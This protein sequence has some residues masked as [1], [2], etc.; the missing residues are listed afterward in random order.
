MTDSNPAKDIVSEFA[1][2]DDSGSGA[3]PLSDQT[4]SAFNDLWNVEDRVNLGTSEG[5]DMSE[6]LKFELETLTIER[7]R[8]KKEKWKLT[9]MLESIKL[10]EEIALMKSEVSALDDENRQLL[11]EIQRRKSTVSQN[12]PG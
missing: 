5:N 8:L 12:T 11:A 1:H 10:E 4:D 3:V 2:I 7:E 6:N 9:E